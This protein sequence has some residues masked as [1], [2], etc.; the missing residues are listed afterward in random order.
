MK[1]KKIIINLIIALIFTQG[2]MAQS[3][4]QGLIDSGNQNLKSR[5]FKGAISDFGNALKAQPADTAALGGIIKACLLSDDLKEAQKHIDNAIK[6]Y[7]QNAEFLFRRGILNNKKGQ[8]E[9]A[10]ED[11]TA[12]LSLNS[13][14]DL[15]VQ[16]YLNLGA[17][18]LKQEDFKLAIE[19]YNKA[20]EL[21]PRNS[22]IYSYRG[23]ANYKLGSY[24]DAIN[25]YNNAI[26]LDPNSA[27]SY[28]NRGMAYLKSLDK[29][30]SCFDFHK[31]CSLGNVNACKMIVSE[32]TSK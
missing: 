32:C 3:N 19:N 22:N 8:F 6:T 9:K 20:L 23:Y 28:Y 11:F 1:M 17:T 26:D 12:A 30:K 24:T 18:N 25:D 4:F 10:V 27:Y 16:I 21:S 14:N 7:P 2:V 29:A 13:S 15:K 5:N 31:A